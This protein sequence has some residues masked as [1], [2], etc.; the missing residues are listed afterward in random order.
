ME[1]GSCWNSAVQ[2]PCPI[3]LQTTEP[4]RWN[5]GTW[6][7]VSSINQ[8]VLLSGMT[9]R[10]IHT[11]CVQRDWKTHSPASFIHLCRVNI[12]P[13]LKNRNKQ[14][15]THKLRCGDLKLLIYS[16]VISRKTYFFLFTQNIKVL[17]YIFSIQE[18]C[19][20]LFSS[21]LWCFRG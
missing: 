12:I 10:R 21:E 2:E 16:A 14:N 5:T 17:K 18:Y 13:H 11:Y 3:H 20:A 15:I 9:R 6:K 8:Y 19:E 4:P 1:R 7:P